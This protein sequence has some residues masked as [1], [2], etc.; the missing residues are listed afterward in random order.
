MLNCREKDFNKW[1][2]WES[3]DKNRLDKKNKDKDYTWLSYRKEEDKNKK[4][5]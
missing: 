2:N 4:D 5:C 1:S 3:K